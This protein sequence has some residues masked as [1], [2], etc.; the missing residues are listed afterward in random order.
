MR[1]RKKLDVAYLKVYETLRQDA[2]W[3]K[4]VSEDDGAHPGAEG[5]RQLASVV[6]WPQWW[7]G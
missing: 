5:Y 1:W 3:M 7:F 6:D 4:E 2:I